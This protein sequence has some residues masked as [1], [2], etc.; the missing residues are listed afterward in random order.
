MSDQYDLKTGVEETARDLDFR[1]HPNPGNG[2]YQIDINTGTAAR[3]ELRVSNQL[4]SEIFAAQDY[5]PNGTLSTEINISD[6]PTGVYYLTLRID[7]RDIYFKK[8]IKE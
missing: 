1:V 3:V 7:G 5:A 4:G 2:I 6:Q 8:L